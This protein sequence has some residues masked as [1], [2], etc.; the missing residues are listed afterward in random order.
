MRSLNFWQIF[1]FLM[2]LPTLLSLSG[3]LAAWLSP[4]GETLRHLSKYVLVDALSNTIALVIG[5]SIVTVVLGVGLAW[6]TAVFNFPGRNFFSWAL[7]LP[8]AIPG[9]V[10]AFAFVGLF[11]YTG[12]VQTQWRVY[13]GSSAGFPDIYSYGGVVTV[14]SLVLYPYL[15]L[16]VRNAFQTQGRRSLEAGSRWGCRPPRVFSA[17]LCRW[18]GR[19]LSP[20]CCWW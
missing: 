15:Y 8:M 3:V 10:M 20:V 9:Y 18:H 2:A 7:I 16:V 1:L 13:F 19:G 4:D 12:T 6:L 11:E 5:V 17:S 14:L